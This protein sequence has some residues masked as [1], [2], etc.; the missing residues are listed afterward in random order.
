[1][2]Y[3]FY[4][5][6]SG[7]YTITDGYFADYVI[8]EANTEKEAVDI[9]EL[10]GAYDLPWCECCGE[11]FGSPDDGTEKPEIYGKSIYTFTEKLLNHNFDDC[12]VKV[13][14]LDGS[15]EHFIFSRREVML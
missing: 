4:Q 9:M 8:I 10:N 15:T 12:P 7:G 11:R 1:M 5:N 13:H 3:T 2:F 14:K 6:N